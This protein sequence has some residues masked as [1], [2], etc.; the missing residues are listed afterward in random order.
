[1]LV[2]ILS[3]AS[4]VG[5]ID[6][7]KIVRSH[8]PKPNPKSKRQTTCQSWGAIKRKSELRSGSGTT[9]VLGREGRKGKQ[10]GDGGLCEAFEGE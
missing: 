5:T 10:R 9:R 2:G 3:T 8:V 1:M 4:D 6:V 7:P